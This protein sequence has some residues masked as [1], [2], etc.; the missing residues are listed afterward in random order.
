MTSTLVAPRFLRR[1]TE[2]GHYWF[3]PQRAQQLRTWCKTA[4]WTKV[5]AIGG[6]QETGFEQAFSSLAYTYVKDKAPR[7]LDFLIG[8]QLVDRSDDNKKAMGVFGFKVGKQWLYAPVFFLNGDLKGHELLYI[9]DQDTFVPMKEN[10][11]NYLIARKP[12]LLGE[13]SDKNTMQLGGLMPNIS[14]LANSPSTGKFAAAVDDWARPLLPLLGACET[15]AA[16][17]FPTQAAHALDLRCLLAQVPALLKTARLVADRY[18]GIQQGLDRFYGP[19]FLAVM[20]YR[21]QQRERSLVTKQAAYGD[22][23]SDVERRM[24][25]VALDDVLGHGRR[26]RA[27]PKAK[28]P[29]PASLVGDAPPPPAHPLKT[30]ALRVVV[31]DDKTITENLPEL[32]D[33]EREKLLRDH[34]LIKDKR[35]PHAI[36]AVYNTQ[37]QMELTNPSETGIYS[38]LEKPASFDDMLVIH[39][40]YTNNSR[41]PFAVLVRLS[42]PR[43]WLNVHPTQLWVKCNR[44][45]DQDDFQKWFAKLPATTTMA[46]D[47][48]YLAI[49]PN[50]SATTPFRVRQVY[51][52]DAYSVNF[53][54]WCSFGNDRPSWLPR[55]ALPHQ[56]D[57]RCSTYDAKLFVGRIKA[58][59]LRSSNCELDVPVGF[60]IFKLAEPPP[61]PKESDSLCACHSMEAPLAGS[62]K[63]PISPGNL[64]DIQLMLYEKTAG[65]KLIDLGS[66]VWVKD[67]QERRL[68]KQAALIHLV[69]GHGVSEAAARAMLS[70]AERKQQASFRIKH[71]QGFHGMSGGLSGGPNAPYFPEPDRGTEQVGYSNYPAQYPYEDEQLVPGLEGSNY[72]QRVYDPFYPPDQGA[73]QVAQQAAQSGQKEVF[74]TTMVGSLLKAVRQDSL[75]DKYLGDLMKALD[76][77]GRILMLFYWHQEEFADRYGKQD[78]PELE[79][80]TRNTFDTLGDL[81]LFLKEKAV[82]GGEG[83]PG[84]NNEAASEPSLEAAS[85]T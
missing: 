22:E 45:P 53:D 80:T 8:F 62:E 33:A 69:T 47:G 56:N 20:A 6:E 17:Y 72:D 30:G 49:G 70:L 4:S 59:S 83:L 21:Q 51:G 32:D 55:T 34:V 19:D 3:S 58:T 23:D 13:A 42:D 14:R 2:V 1:H 71:A 82:N 28:P 31:D 78:L 40:P 48:H 57:N 9:K 5:A 15:K 24:R 73:L 11:V 52:D 67:A 50:G 29:V 64:A 46:K 66:E 39:H 38:V 36:S 63:R 25:L 75:V 35:D 43:A 65:V 16:N 44:Q 81:T 84:V 77:I 54:D 74:D 68:T 7:L 10:W 27:K 41:E 61:P 79:D 18:P 37:V 85:R 26:Q 12:H 60:K 76:K